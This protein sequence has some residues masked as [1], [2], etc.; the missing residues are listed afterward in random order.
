MARIKTLTT[1]RA[2]C[3]RSEPADPD[4]CWIWKGAVRPNGH[5]AIWI[6]HPETGREMVVGGAHAVAILTGKVVPKPGRTWTTC[7]DPLCCHPRHAQAGTYAEWGAW[8]KESGQWP[9][10]QRMRVAAVARGRALSKIDLDIARAMRES[11]LPP[12]QEAKVWSQKLGTRISHD[13]VCDVRAGRRW[14]E[15]NPFRALMR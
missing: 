14:P 11:P 9:R 13:V 8:K 12:L 3:R 5:A 7:G 15:P 2:R 10:T 1:L 6:V 4:C